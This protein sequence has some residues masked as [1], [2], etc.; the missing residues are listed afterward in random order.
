MVARLSARSVNAEGH[1]Q[2]GGQVF[3]AARELGCD[4]RDILDFSANINPL[5]LP[6]SARRALMDSLD[7][8]VHYPESGAP[9]V[10]AAAAKAWGLPVDRILVGNGATEL[11][12]SL[13]RELHPRRAHLAVPTFS[14]YRRALDKCAVSTTTWDHREGDEAN[15]DRI[16]RDASERDTGLLIL[17]NPNNPTGHMIPSEALA[18]KLIDRLPVAVRVLVDESFIDFTRQPSVAALRE[19]RGLFILRSLTKFYA[20]P[21]LRIGCLIGD[22]ADIVDLVSSR[23]PWQ[24]NILAEKAAAAALAD[25]EFHKRSIAFVERER[26]WLSDKLTGL[27]GIKPLP[28]AANFILCCSESGVGRLAK[29]LFRR[30]ILIRDCTATEGVEG[31]AFRVAVR[32]RTENERLIACMEEFLD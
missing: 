22:P 15:L 8:V 26:R 23:A 14:E 5:G 17:T 12:H 18:A 29:H 20:M 6:D 21:G 1:E 32:T 2:H 7:A 3:R 10:Q 30:R 31:S 16:A 25:V 9:G 27:S 4:W 13:I 24:T 11:I 19:R 28:S